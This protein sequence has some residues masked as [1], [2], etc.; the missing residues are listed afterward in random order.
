MQVMIAPWIL[1]GQLVLLATLTLSFPY[2]D[3]NDELEAV[4][5][6]LAHP[7]VITIVLSD[8]Q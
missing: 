5:R 3:E 6:M 8:F 4:K 2:Y 7:Q 1:L